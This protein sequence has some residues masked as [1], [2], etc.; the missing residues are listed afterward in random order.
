[1]TGGLG[2]SFRIGDIVVEPASSRVTRQDGTRHVEPRAMDVLVFLAQHSGRVVSRDELIRAVWKHPNVTDDALSRCISLLR[3]A[4][5]DDSA[6][7]R[8]LA[9]VPK[10]GYQLIATVTPETAAPSPADTPFTVAVLPFQNL[11]GDPNDEYISDGITE[12]LISNLA[13]LPSLRVISRTSSMHYK[14]TQLR[15]AE[16]AGELGANRIVEGSVLRSGD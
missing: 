2:N 16:I 13:C 6:Q 11:C 15:L 12:L 8:F 5:G 4:L 7:P 3:Q 14:G 9:T 1:M 10:R